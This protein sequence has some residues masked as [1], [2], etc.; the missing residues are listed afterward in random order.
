MPVVQEYVNTVKMALLSLEEG[1]IDPRQLSL[2]TLV[3]E[4]NQHN[5]PAWV[6]R[7]L[8]NALE[9]KRMEKG[10]GWS[11]PWNKYGLNIFRAHKHQWPNDNEL[12]N[13]IG[14]VLQIVLKDASEAYRV[15]AQELLLNPLKMAF[16]FYHNH[17]SDGGDYEGITLSIGRKVI[18]DPTKRDRLDIILED[19]K[20]SDQVDGK[21]DKIRIYINPWDGNK[22]DSIFVFE[23][24]VKED[25]V[26][27][28][29]FFDLYQKGI[30]FYN[31]YKNEKE[32]QWS[33][34]A[35]RYIDYFGP[36]TFIPK[37]SQFL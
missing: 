1:S 28:T 21:L 23:Q 7:L 15:F 5:K 9:K 2:G 31:R 20:I 24:D 22:K 29:E 26:F 8:M 11:R 35:N 3:H 34:W 17:R 36:R 18:A 6:L 16:T 19:L 25:L 27:P 33:H 4:I 13:S 32:R 37:G 10:L 14:A 12:F 30:E